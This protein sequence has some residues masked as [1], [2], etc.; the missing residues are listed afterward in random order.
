MEL[1]LKNNSD[2][3][4]NHLLDNRYIVIIPMTNPHGYYQKIREELL[5]Q[6]ENSATLTNNLYKRTHKDINRDFPYLTKHES[7]MET[8]GARVI[9]ELYVNHLFSVA[10]SLHGGTESFTYP[11][12][13][14]NHMDR[15]N[16][17]N[18]P[19]SYEIEDGK[20]VK[21][22][23]QSD[24]EDRARLFRN[25]SY[26]LTFGKSSEPPDAN[27]LSCKEIFIKYFKIS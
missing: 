11:Y 19:M 6:D 9:N 27:A 23:P 22:K 21:P 25:G 24:S 14:P 2:P 8:I 13:T 3:W 10:L 12:G 15:K 17:P 16:I 1:I 4:F 7:C 20:A 26:D 5:I 18:V